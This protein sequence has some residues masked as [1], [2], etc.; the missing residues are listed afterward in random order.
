MQELQP[1][2]KACTSPPQKDARKSHSER[3]IF[4]L[5]G[6]TAQIQL[7]P[8]IGALSSIFAL[9]GDCLP[10]ALAQPHTHPGA[11]L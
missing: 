10:I 2:L 9:F 6:E 7:P 8:R 4:L 11:G 1:T 5:L 3:P